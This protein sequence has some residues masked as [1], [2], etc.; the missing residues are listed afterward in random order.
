M[1]IRISTLHI[2]LITTEKYTR[3]FIDTITYYTMIMAV[4]RSGYAV[5]S[6]SPRNSPAAIAHLIKSGGIRCILV[7][8]EQSMWDLTN[9]SLYALKTDYGAQIAEP[10]LIPMPYFEDL[11]RD[12]GDSFETLPSVP[13][14]PDDIVMYIHSSGIYH[15]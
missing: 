12:T 10:Q 13:E 11:F 2:F 3:C 14:G 6:I 4:I 7:G 5:I 15:P 1:N 8:R 9:A